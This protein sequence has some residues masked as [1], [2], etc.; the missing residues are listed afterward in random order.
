MAAYGA[1]WGGLLAVL[2]WPVDSVSHRGRQAAGRWYC[3]VVNATNW[4]Q[5]TEF[6]F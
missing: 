1:Q 3:L 2:E 4:K 5:G 6:K